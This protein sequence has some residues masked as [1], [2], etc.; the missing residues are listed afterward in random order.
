[1][2]SPAR[3]AAL[4]TTLAV[5][6][7]VLLLANALKYGLISEAFFSEHGKTV[8]GIGKIVTPIVLLIGAVASYFRFFKGRT[9]S[10]RAELGITV[11]VIRASGEENLHAISIRLKNI[12][13]VPLWDP[14]ISLRIQAYGPTPSA[15]VEIKGWRLEHTDSTDG[16]EA[17]VIDSQEYAL[18]HA[19][20]LV[21]TDIW[22]VRYEAAVRT[23]AGDT[24]FGMTTIANT[25]P[26]KGSG[27]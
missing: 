14:T 25:V 22:A 10:A 4:A 11:S 12:G 2:I 20:R 1:M 3:R 21:A 7:A 23:A 18:Y 16:E 13:P 5:A 15:P 19:D 8:E 9:F 26:A 27:V 17:C 24:W 6:M